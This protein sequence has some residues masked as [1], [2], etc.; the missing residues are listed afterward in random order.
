MNE[1]VFV[2]SDVCLD[3]LLERATFYKDAQRLFTKAANREIEISISTL[4]F[5]NLY[6]V[7]K[8]DNTVAEARK[9][10]GRFKQLVRILPVGDKVIDLA[11]H[12]DFADFE[13]GVQYYVAVE[14]GIKTM[15]TRNLKDYKP[16][17]IPVFTPQAFLKAI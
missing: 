16:A 7:V 4:V 10:M 5:C 9:I 2:D 14:N 1:R 3:L 13:D 11:L 17:Q 15:V 12:S 8:K 6:Y